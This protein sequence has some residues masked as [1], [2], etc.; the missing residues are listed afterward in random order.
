[1]TGDPAPAAA[2]DA[3]VRFD[4]VSKSFGVRHVVQAVHGVTFSVLA[5]QFVAIVGPS[6]SGKTTLIRLAAGL[7]TP[8]SGT[9]RIGVETP[10]EYRRRRSI[11][12]V[13]QK[14]SLLGWRTARENALLPTEFSRD[15][16]RDREAVLGRI[17][18]LLHIREFEDLY[19]HELSG[20]IAQRVA[21]ARALMCDSPLVLLD[22]PFSALDAITREQVWGDIANTFNEERATALMV[23]HHI[24][25]AVAMSDRIVVVSPRPARVVGDVG[26]DAER[27]RDRSFFESARAKRV[28]EEVRDLLR[29]GSAAG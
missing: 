15:G 19:P 14:V 9:V 4:G 18:D 21:V 16:T 26:V 28:E 8:D 25:E 13:P 3:L 20:G 27:P 7:I 11:G 6:G 24:A 23:T 17:F 2:G 29:A 10:G 12:Y 22:E 1:M 5:R